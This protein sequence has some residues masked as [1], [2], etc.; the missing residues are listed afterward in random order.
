MVPQIIPSF[1]I[2]KY[3]DIKILRQY[4]F[5]KKFAKL[6]GMHGL[7]VGGSSFLSPMS[8]FY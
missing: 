8:G 5:G 4:I 1:E 2:F 6:G 3:F 7:L